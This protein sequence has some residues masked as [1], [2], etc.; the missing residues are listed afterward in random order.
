MLGTSSVQENPWQL[1]D[2]ATEVFDLLLLGSKLQSHR[3][4]ASSF[5]G[6]LKHLVH[7]ALSKNAQLTDQSSFLNESDAFMQQM[8]LIKITH[9]A[10]ISI[11]F[12]AFDATYLKIYH[13]HNTEKQ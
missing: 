7:V 11:R 13:G 9:V 1:V 2:M 3:Q 4:V 5:P 12:R 10:T 8:D 6:N